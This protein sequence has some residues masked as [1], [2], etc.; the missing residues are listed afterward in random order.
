[1]DRSLVSFA[2]TSHEV[3]QVA[4]VIGQEI[5][6]RSLGLL[7]FDFGFLHRIRTT[8]T[9]INKPGFLAQEES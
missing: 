8:L 1:M 7:N 5:H 6:G 3:Q 4:E 2:G 9:I